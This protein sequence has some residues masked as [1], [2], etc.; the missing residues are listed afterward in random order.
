MDFAVF[1]EDTKPWEGI[2]CFSAILFF[3]LFFPY[4]WVRFNLPRLSIRISYVT[5]MPK[6][7]LP[8][9]ERP[10]TL[11]WRDDNV[12]VMKRSFKKRFLQRCIY[13]FITL[14]ITL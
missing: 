3:C 1:L 6:L 11:G 5:P 14:Y 13:N 4:R 8:A 10:N 9:Q 12:A 2:T 7:Q